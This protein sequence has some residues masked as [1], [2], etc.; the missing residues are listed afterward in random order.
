MFYL[1]LI[2]FSFAFALMRHHPEFYLSLLVIHLVSQHWD[3]ILGS[4]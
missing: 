2:V 4:V 3:A 1:T